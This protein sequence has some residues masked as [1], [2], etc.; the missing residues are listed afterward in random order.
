MEDLKT[1]LGG[2][3]LSITLPSSYWYIKHF[4]IVHLEKHVHWFNVSRS[5]LPS[6]YV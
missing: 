6:G 2:K 3:G 4:D 5:V 1:S